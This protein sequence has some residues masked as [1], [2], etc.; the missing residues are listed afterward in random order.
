MVTVVH[1]SQGVQGLGSATPRKLL[2]LCLVSIFFIYKT[3]IESCAF[4]NSWDGGSGKKEYGVHRGHMNVAEIVFP[5]S[6]IA[7]G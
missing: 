1:R 3:N 5:L 2:S 6:H 7:W 4:S